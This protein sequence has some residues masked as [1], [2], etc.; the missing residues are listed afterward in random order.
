MAPE[1]RVSFPRLLVQG[2]R[3]SPKAT[4][5]VVA[6]LATVLTPTAALAS[7]TRNPGRLAGLAPQ[8]EA[9]RPAISV[10]VQDIT[11][12][13]IRGVTVSF[14]NEKTQEQMGFKT[15]DDGTLR[16]T[17][18]ASGQYQLTFEANGFCTK[19]I[20]HVSVPREKVLT[21]TLDV[22]VVVEDGS[23]WLGPV[24]S[25]TEPDAA[26]V[27]SKLTEPAVAQTEAAKQ[28]ISIVVLDEAGGVMPGVDATFRNEKTKEKTSA[29]TGDDGTVKIGTLANGRYEVTFW[30]AGYRKTVAHIKV[31]SEKVLRVTLLIG[32][33][34][35]IDEKDRPIP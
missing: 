9:A 23:G 14:R 1:E 8:N 5:I 29:K 35:T 4:C 25:T 30:M 19:K 21:V 20:A 11:G 27:G 17:V 32:T 7:P 24:A 13:V 26:P 12:A 28:S 22:C 34:T 33:V 2:R 10:V 3:W 16:P 31:P 6:T 15:D 18:L